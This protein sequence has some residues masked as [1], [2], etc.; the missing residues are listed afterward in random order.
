[1]SDAYRDPL[2]SLRAQVETKREVVHELDRRLTPL[3]RRVLDARTLGALG[4]AE[5]KVERRKNAPTFEAMSALDR[6]LDAWGA[7][8]RAA[9]TESD[10]RFATVESIG[11]LVPTYVR[12]TPNVVGPMVDRVHAELSRVLVALTRERADIWTGFIRSDLGTTS[13]TVE[14]CDMVEVAVFLRLPFPDLRGTFLLTEKSLLEG[15]AELV[16]LLVDDEVRA[17]LSRL[18][19]L[20][21]ERPASLGVGHDCATVAYR[22]RFRGAAEDLHLEIPLALF[23]ALLRPIRQF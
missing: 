5:T 23:A 16:R 18:A 10:A 7:I 3:R 19:A 11:A 14:A 2:A 8:L 15:D 6:D 20:S 12:D 21:K 13:V 9:I 17:A 22:A 4:E 1:M